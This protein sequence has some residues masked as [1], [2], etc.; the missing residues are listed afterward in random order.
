LKPSEKKKPG[1]FNK[2]E[3]IIMALGNIIG[4][5][6]FLASGLVIGTAGAWAPLAY[7]AGGIIMSMEVAA[8]GT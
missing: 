8:N 3:F 7:L 2:T 1:A 4:S 6:I 5:G